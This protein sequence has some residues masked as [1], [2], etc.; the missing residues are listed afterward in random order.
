MAFLLFVFFFKI[1]GDYDSIDRLDDIDAAVI[2]DNNNTKYRKPTNRKKYPLPDDD[3]E[4]KDE[5]TVKCLYY[6]L[7]CCECTIS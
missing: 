2:F 3:N 5:K 7:M 1:Q 4:K 6:T